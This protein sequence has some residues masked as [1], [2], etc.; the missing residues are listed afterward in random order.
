MATA[1]TPALLTAADCAHMRGQ[2]HR[3]ELIRGVLCE[4]PPPQGYEHG[5]AVARVVD[6]IARALDA[7]Q[8]GRLVVGSGGVRLARDPDTVRTPD[9]AFTL[10]V[11]LP[12]GEPLRS[13]WDV[14]P[15]LVVEIAAPSARRAVAHDKAQMWVAH[16]VHIAWVVDPDMR[17]VDVYRAN[18][19][20]R[21][22]CA[23][24]SL[25]GGDVVPGLHCAV[26][27]LF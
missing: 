25:D 14:A 10:A 1:P 13:Y 8:L 3:V 12:F 4:S 17:S 5:E 15:D 18:A 23:S 20:T 24:D 22:L 16:G 19:A 2:G 21:T 6:A 11:R 9:I 27:S 26:E 7:G